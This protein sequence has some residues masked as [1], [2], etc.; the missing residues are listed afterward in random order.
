MYSTRNVL[1]IAIYKRDWYCV[2]LYVDL[3]CRDSKAFRERLNEIR[4][5][6]GFTQEEAAAVLGVVRPT[7][8]YYE[9]DRTTLKVPD[10]KILVVP[11]Y[12][13]I[14][15]PGRLY[16]DERLLQRSHGTH[17]LNQKIGLCPR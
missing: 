2:L 14:N 5:W 16:P 17:D 15:Y 10:L 13:D 1:M 11:F 12:G 3:L 8:S 9:L 6:A 7:H 4:I